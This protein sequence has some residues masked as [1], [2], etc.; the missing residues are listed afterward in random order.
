MYPRQGRSINLAH[1]TTPVPALEPS[2]VI[3]GKSQVFFI[4]ARADQGSAGL[5]SA[6][7]LHVFLFGHIG[8]EVTL[9]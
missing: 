5:G 7:T 4:K 2:C 9:W 1:S 8:I 6:L 3:P